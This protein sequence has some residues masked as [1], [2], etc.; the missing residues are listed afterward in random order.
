MAAP[1]ATWAWRQNQLLDAAPWLQRLMSYAWPGYVRKLRNMLE[2][3]V[4]MIREGPLLPAHLPRSFGML[5]EQ[6]H[7]MVPEREA[8]RTINLEGGKPLREV[9]N[10]HILQFTLKSTDNNKK[11]AAESLG[12]S[13]RTFA[14][15]AGRVRGGRK[16]TL[17]ERVRIRPGFA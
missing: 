4:I 8:L 10:A 13:M 15:L 6:Q 11:H 17:R 1:E 5:P 2:R 7:Q 9:E 12:I 3:A 16:R 14:Q